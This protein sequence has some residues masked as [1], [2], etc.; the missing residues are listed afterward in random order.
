MRILIG[1]CRRLRHSSVPPHSYPDP[2]DCPNRLRPCRCS[3]DRFDYMCAQPQDK[4][5]P[6]QYTRLLQT[7]VFIWVSA[8]EIESPLGPE[9]LGNRVHLDREHPAPLIRETLFLGDSLEYCPVWI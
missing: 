2:A 8:C 6:E 1:C 7:A 3:Y 5:V 4:V 9:F